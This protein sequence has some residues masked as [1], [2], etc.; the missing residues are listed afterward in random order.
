MDSNPNSEESAQWC[1]EFFEGL[2]SDELLD[3]ISASNYIEFGALYQSACRAAAQTL[4]GKSAEEIRQI[5]R[6]QEN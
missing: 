4:V 3:L 1:R 5:L 2:S 6:L